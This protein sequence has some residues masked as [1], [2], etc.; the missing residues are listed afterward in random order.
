MKSILTFLTICLCALAV[1]AESVTLYSDNG[2]GGIH[3]SSGKTIVID[4][5]YY[6]DMTIPVYKG[7]TKTERHK[8]YR[9]KDNARLYYNQAKWAEK[10]KYVVEANNHVPYYFNM[11]GVWKP[12]L[13]G[14]NNPDNTVPQKKLT[15]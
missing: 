9:V 2:Q 15:A 1:N 11:K 12:S 5:Q 13:T 8:V 3:Q 7:R 14:S 4:G 10:Y 6:V